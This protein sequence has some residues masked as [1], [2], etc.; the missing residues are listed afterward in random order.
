MEGC[1]CVIVIN[2]ARHAVIVAGDVC[3]MAEWFKDPIEITALL[4][5]G[6]HFFTEKFLD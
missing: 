4:I 1:G 2:E 3:Y 5:I 6:Q